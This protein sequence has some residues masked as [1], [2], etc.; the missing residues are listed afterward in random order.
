MERR[1]PDLVV[2]SYGLRG[3]TQSNPKILLVFF[4]I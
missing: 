4:I 3:D 1:T 2:R